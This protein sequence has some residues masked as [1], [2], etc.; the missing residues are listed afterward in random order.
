MK[1]FTQAFRLSKVFF[2]FFGA[3][4]AVRIRN[5]GRRKTGKEND[6]VI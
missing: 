1:D 4:R 2:A 6:S 3:V 5:D